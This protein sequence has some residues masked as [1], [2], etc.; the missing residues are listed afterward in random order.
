MCR[1]FIIATVGSI[2]VWGAPVR[3]QIQT[4]EMPMPPI[5]ESASAPL[6][7]TLTS[8]VIETPDDLTAVR[9]QYR[10]ATANRDAAA[11]I[12]LFAEDGVLVASDRDVVRGRRISG[13]TSRTRSIRRCRK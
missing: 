9:E 11:L 13:S 1:V 4:R 6:H 3:A 7:E 5:G 10:A 2:A 8:G 12:D